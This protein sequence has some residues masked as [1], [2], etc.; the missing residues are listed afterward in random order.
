L[1]PYRLESV[2]GRGG[3]GEV[4]KATDTRLNRPVAIKLCDPGFL[5]YF[6]REVKAIS[7]LNHPHICTL[8]DAGPDYLVMELIEGETLASRIRKGPLTIEEV[9]RYGAEIADALAEA[10]S[11]GIVHRDLKPGN[12]MI[13]RRGVKVLDF[14]L[15]KSAAP[16]QD[17]TQSYRLAG[18][19]AYMAPEQV[20]GKGVD[21]RT[22]LFALGLVLFEMV[23]GR[24]PFPGASL[25]NM[26]ASDNSSAIPK[27]SQ[28]RDRTFSPLD[29][30]ILKL[31]DANPEKRFQQA[32][33]VAHELQA[34]NKPGSTRVPKVGIAAA[35]AVVMLT[36]L[37]FTTRT[38]EV[39]RLEVA[40]IGPITNLRG[41]KSDPAYSPD[42]SHVAFSWSGQDGKSPG[43]YVLAL[44]DT[45]PRRLTDARDSIGDVAPAWSPDGKQI[46]FER[47]KR[48]EAQELIIVD[49]MG[50]PERKLRD[51]K[52][53]APLANSARP[54]LTWTPDGSAVVAPTADVDADN[55]ASLLRIGVRGE[56]ARRL[57][58]STAGDGDALPAFSQDGRWLAYASVERASMRLFVRPIGRD[59]MPA[60]PSVE[61]PRGVGNRSDQLRSPVWSPD[62]RSLVFGVGGTLMAWELGGTSQEVW[63]SE[64]RFQG[65][66]VHWA[67]GVLSHLAYSP[68]VFRQ[69]LRELRLDAEGR[70]A[71]GPSVEF[72]P[73][74]TIGNP[75]F[76]PDGRWL[77][78]N[79]EGRAES[80]GP[81]SIALW[82]ASADGKTPRLLSNLAAGSGYRFSPD[83]RH[84][85]F[86][87]VTES[88]APLYV[89][90]LDAE[91]A[92][93][94]ERK[95]AQTNSFAL[96]GASWSA[97]GEYLYTTA[98]K[99][100][101]Q[102]FRANV[103][104]GELEDLFE[105]RTPVVAPDGSRIFYSKS[106]GPGLFARSLENITATTNLEEQIATECVKAWGMVPTA[107]GIYYVGCDELQVPK[108][109]R[110]FEFSS[111]RSFDV[112]E[113]PPDE[114][115]ALTVSPDGRRLVYATTLP[116]DSELTRVTF[117]GAKP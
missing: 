28:I 107:R 112:G 43:I 17:W 35:A 93:K 32:R 18:T 115:P 85:A 42:G 100:P 55:R 102:V 97:D 22:D 14:G 64:A 75:Q 25:G 80:S 3:M 2:V 116:N 95:V 39:Q 31:L 13:T 65:F 45:D 40:G 23:T 79:S 89:V 92:A 4:Y 41:S 99:T 29:P 98:L 63:V 7:A 110:Y 51:L 96:V 67:G 77:A 113:A 30:L 11:A 48:N 57:F 66:S 88:P 12:I 33:T 108:A 69:Q 19:P 47:L 87:N 84:V 105:G 9:R 68:E 20:S 50:G 34:L 54:L 62:S 27:P 44:G 56:P 21:P 24:T 8:Y 70:R 59:G 78:F 6:Q 83:S 91:G 86:H 37:W 106:G 104:T 61:V 49:A 82:I 53:S 15:A 74:G 46:A 114:Q 90:D 58:E 73:R 38:R 103:R 109:I 117:R 52:Q 81:A 101:M 111:R 76:S 60:G 1:G 72:I 26:L 5:E 16:G 10:H 71:E 94:A 36:L